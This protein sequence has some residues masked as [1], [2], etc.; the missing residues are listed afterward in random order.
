[1]PGLSA[2]RQHSVSRPSSVSA[3]RS[4]RARRSRYIPVTINAVRLLRRYC[5]CRDGDVLLCQP[6]SSAALTCI[7][8]PD[9]AGGTRLS[10]RSHGVFSG[11][12]HKY[13]STCCLTACMHDC[14]HAARLPWPEDHLVNHPRC[15][16]REAQPA[17]RVRTPTYWCRWLFHIADVSGGSGA[18]G[19]SATRTI[20]ASALAMPVWRADVLSPTRPRDS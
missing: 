18:A 14:Q 4:L 7:C 10:L 2:A 1:L 19:R 20:W 17:P 3:Q 15:S 16:S 9:G 5:I 13:I 12:L 6:S 8:L 11:R